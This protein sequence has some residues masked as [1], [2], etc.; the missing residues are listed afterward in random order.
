[1][2]TEKSCSLNC[3]GGLIQSKVQVI[4]EMMNIE[5][6]HNNGALK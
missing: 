3:S 1:M 5:Y 6:M 2:K 4:E